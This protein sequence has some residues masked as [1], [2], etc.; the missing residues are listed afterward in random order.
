MPVKITI[1]N[2]PKEVRD[3]IAARAAARR[4][5]MQGYLLGE[6]KRIASMPTNGAWL[7]E[8]RMRKAVRKTRISRTNILRARD[9]DRA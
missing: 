4:Q 1:R 2:V 5:S 6:L 3:K 7:E 9:A 8:V